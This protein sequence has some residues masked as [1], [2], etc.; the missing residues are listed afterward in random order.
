MNIC[1]R[2][3]YQKGLKPKRAK[4]KE[5][6]DDEAFLAWIRRQPSCISGAFSEFLE[7]GEGRCVPAHVRR[8]GA[9]GTAY[10]PLFSAVPLTKEE[11]D[12]THQKGEEILR[13]KE[14]WNTQ[15]KLYLARWRLVEKGLA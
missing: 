7:N 14:W 1:G 13:P 10:K 6:R 8:A 5:V 3:I 11:H 15:A 12:L 4:S 2:P 9:A